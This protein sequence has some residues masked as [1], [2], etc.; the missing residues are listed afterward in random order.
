MINDVLNE[1][2]GAG[3][4]DAPVSQDVVPSI[5]DTMPATNGEREEEEKQQQSSQ[6]AA[7]AHEAEREGEAIE[8]ARPPQQAVAA[9]SPPTSMASSTLNAPTPAPIPTTPVANSPLP[10]LQSPALL[11]PRSSIA[12]TSPYQH[13]LSSPPKSTHRKTGL[14]KTYFSRTHFSS[15]FAPKEKGSGDMTRLVVRILDGRDLLASDV[16]T[17]KSDPLCFIWCCSN[18]VSREVPWKSVSQN[19]WS[20]IC[21]SSTPFSLPGT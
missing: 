7:T 9:A 16:Q 15:P 20:K 18:Q 14:K 3:G 12:S 21:N 17:G 1:T 11:G 13:S 5:S 4:L 8:E 6:T 19:V 10:P 2:S